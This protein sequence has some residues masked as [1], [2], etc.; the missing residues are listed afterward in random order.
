MMDYK[1]IAKDVWEVKPIPPQGTSRQEDSHCR[2][3][4]EAAIR[5]GQVILWCMEPDISPI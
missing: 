3:R 4:A 2:E 1:S 5:I